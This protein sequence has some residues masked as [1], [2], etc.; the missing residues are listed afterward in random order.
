MVRLQNSHSTGGE[1][2]VL[3]PQFD[4]DVLKHFEDNPPTSTREVFQTGIDRRF[5]LSVE[6]EQQLHPFHRQK[7]RALGPND[8]ICREKFVRSFVHQP[9]FPATVLFINEACFS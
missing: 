1:Q 2:S 3:T 4:K 8:Y 9:D 5:V 6:R 7:L